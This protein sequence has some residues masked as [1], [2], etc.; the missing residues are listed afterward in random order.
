MAVDKNLNN[1]RIVDSFKRL[2]QVDPNDNKT[3]LNGTGSNITYQSSYTHVTM[4]VATDTTFTSADSGKYIY[5]THA[6]NGTS[7]EL[8]AVADCIGCEFTFITQVAR[9]ADI[10]WDAQAAD[11]I[12]GISWSGDVNGRTTGSAISARY[13]RYDESNGISSNGSIG[14]RMKLNCDGA[15]YYIDAQAQVKTTATEPVWSGSSA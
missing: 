5:I 3:L 4:S 10:K 13:I 12:R 11:K 9:T 8:P 15:Y 6:S 14:D 2:V 7:H 1:F